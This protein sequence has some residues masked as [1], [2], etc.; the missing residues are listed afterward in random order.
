MVRASPLTLFQRCL[1]VHGAAANKVWTATIKIPEL[2]ETVV[3]SSIPDIRENL[4]EAARLVA[5]YLKM[6]KGRTLVITGAGVST[7]S[8]I[9]D[10]RGDEGTYIKNPKHRP[11]LF[12]ELVSSDMFRRRY[13][14]RAF[15]G[16][17]EM[18]KARP[19]PTHDILAWLMQHNYVPD[20]ITQNVD[21][22][23]RRAAAA[24][25]LE[26]SKERSDRIVELHGT[27]FRVEC[28]DCHNMVD[29]Q[30]YQRRLFSRNPSWATL[31]TSG[32]KLKVNPDGDVELSDS[33]S[34]ADFDIPPCTSCASRRMKPQVVFFGENIK[35]H[36]TSAAEAMVRQSDAVFIVGSSLATYSSYRLVR[37]A[38]ELQKPVGILCKGSTRADAL[39]AWKVGMGCTP[40]LQRVQQLLKEQE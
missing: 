8:G 13:W 21:Y 32:E 1:A 16:W 25:A 9:P 28:L 10:Y 38:S 27:L 35:P 20:L 14:A 4:D 30:D 26:H 19:N 15:M 36:V 23:H 3:S 37:L 40:V 11:I 22:L 2:K 12:Q 39:A 31:L 24:A 33:M 34:Y 17:G 6:Y 29:R 7:D 18:A 5:D